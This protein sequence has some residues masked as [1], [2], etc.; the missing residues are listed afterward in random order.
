[1]TAS[2]A[3]IKMLERWDG[4]AFST[5]IF[6]PITSVASSGV[7]EIAQPVSSGAD[8]LSQM[9]PSSQPPPQP[10]APAPE[11]M[12]NPEILEQSSRNQPPE[13]G[14]CTANSPIGCHSCCRCGSTWSC[15]PRLYG[16]ATGKRIAPAL[17][18]ADVHADADADADADAV[19]V[20]IAAAAAATPAS[21][22]TGRHEAT[23][24][25][26]CIRWRQ[27]IDAQRNTI[28][29]LAG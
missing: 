27:R 4:V 15:R 9:A 17:I 11:A 25:L 16:T 8:G 28:N 29:N 10:A 19:A 5:G 24:K 22:L 2:A 21:P 6:D 14:C 3:E 26:E 20:A 7:F 13:A 18:P 12:A 1:M 23:Y